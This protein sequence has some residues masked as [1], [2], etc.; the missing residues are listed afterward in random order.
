MRFLGLRGKVLTPWNKSSV[1][2]VLGFAMLGAVA[3]GSIPSA[4]NA[5]PPFSALTVDAR[6]GKIIGR[7]R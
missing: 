6:T 1:L 2:R 5:A 3:A 7:S 4:A